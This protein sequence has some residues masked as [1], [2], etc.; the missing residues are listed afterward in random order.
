MTRRIILY[1]LISLL[2]VAFFSVILTLQATTTVIGKRQETKVRELLEVLAYIYSEEGPSFIDSFKTEDY[3]ITLLSP[4]GEIMNKV[5]ES[6]W[7]LVTDKSAVE[8]FILDVMSEKETIKSR[9][10]PFLFGNLILAGIYTEDGNILVASTTLRTFGDTIS[11]MRLE[12]LYIILVSVLI[13]SFLA[14]LISYIIVQPLNEINVEEPE[15]VN[16]NKYRE[17]L[18]LINKIAEQKESIITQE[19]ML[20]EEKGRFRAISE[21]LVEGMIL[22][23]ADGTISYINKSAVSILALGEYPTGKKIEAL[24]NAELEEVITRT[25]DK[26]GENSVIY[27]GERAFKVESEHL[28]LSDGGYNGVSVLL[29]DV[30]EHMALERERRE[31]TSNVSHELKTPLHIISGSAELLRLGIVKEEDKKTFVDQIYNESR[32]MKELIDDIIKLSRLDENGKTIEKERIR[33]LDTAGSI[34]ESLRKVA[35]EKNISFHLKGDDAYIECN[36]SMFNQIL[37]NLVDNAVKYSNPDGR[38]SLTVKEEKGE[39]IID[40]KDN[41]IGIPKEYHDRIFERFFRVDKSRS[42]EVGGTGLGLAIVKN[43]C[44]ENGGDVRVE[45]SVVGEGTTFRV[46]FPSSKGGD[47]EN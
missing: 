10:V 31:F 8:E 11:D 21:A 23:E 4:D 1:V 37:Y 36:R 5:Y 20:E 33:V 25:M 27:I 26:S 13:S 3:N 34:M 6:S 12:L 44:L 14:R 40:V 16:E 29:Y 45:S 18:P 30:T 2:L 24:G 28:F 17:I 41:G 43:S 9:N 39:V 7:Y 38:V 35:L 42:K 47:G 19:K 32:R 46:T 15:K 22:V